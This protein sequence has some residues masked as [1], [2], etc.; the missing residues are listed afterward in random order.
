M[1]FT[2]FVYVERSAKMAGVVLETLSNRKLI[3]FGIILLLVQLAFFLI[4]GLIGKLDNAETSRHIL[5]YTA[6]NSPTD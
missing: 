5:T 1:R 4:G 2:A 6:V 3:V